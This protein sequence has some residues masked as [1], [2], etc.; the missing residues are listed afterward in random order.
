M[1]SNSKFENTLSMNG[2]EM[3]YEL[4]GE[5][6]PL[7]IL[8]GFTGSGAG[9]AELFK[10]LIAT[11]QLIIP[12]LRGHGRSTNPSKQFTFRQAA[13]D[14]FALLGHLNI[15]KCKAVGFSGG[16]CVLLQ[17]AYQQP[18]RIK[19]MIIVSATPYFPQHA[20]EIMKQFTVDTR[21][22]EEWEAMRKLHFYGDE[23]IKML[24]EQAR[25]FSESYDDMNFTAEMLTQIQAKTLIVQGD[26]DPIYPIAQTME[27]Y[28]YI[29]NAYLW[30]IPN[31]GHVPITEDLIPEFVRYTKK[32]I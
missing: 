10:P 2:F 11:H 19:A 12:D 29:P 5:G 32:F 23:Q 22:A 18:E 15:S 1:M 14:I 31:G 7:L 24:W 16:G 21:Q 8:H 27:M 13:L 30:I 25:N 20:R 17:M 9:L 3:H 28:E 4:H 26:R 6:S